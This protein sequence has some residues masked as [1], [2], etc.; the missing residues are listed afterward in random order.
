MVPAKK[1]LRRRNKARANGGLTDHFLGMP[2]WTG[3]IGTP[4]AV[5]HPEVAAEAECVGCALSVRVLRAAQLPL[6]SE[7]L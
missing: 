3:F 6:A 2:R 4:I 7:V 5:Q 1:N